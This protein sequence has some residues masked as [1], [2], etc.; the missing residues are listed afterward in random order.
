M[1]LEFAVD[2]LHIIGDN[3]NVK[4]LSE[5]KV[6]E[7]K[8]ANPTGK[9]GAP[10]RFDTELRVYVEQDMYDL[11]AQEAQ[12]EHRNVSNMVRVLLSEAIAAR[13]EAQTATN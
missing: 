11:V 3:R 10:K 2:I 1:L 7:R 13:S 12:S 5:K 4:R 6:G 9:R 8:T